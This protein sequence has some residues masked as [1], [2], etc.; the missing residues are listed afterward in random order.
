MSCTI[1]GDIGQTGLIDFRF[2]I[3]DTL[4]AGIFWTN[5]T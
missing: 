5:K 1:A 3:I 2:Y 4:L